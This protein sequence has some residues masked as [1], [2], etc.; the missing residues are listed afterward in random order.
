MCRFFVARFTE[1]TEISSYLHAFSVMAKDS[2]TSNGDRQGDGWGISF[3]TEN[4]EFKTYKSLLPIWEDQEAFTTIP[5]AKIFL[6]H[7]RSASFPNQVGNLNYNQPFIDDDIGFV[8]NGA[9]TGV[10]TP[11]QLNGTIGSQKIFFL[12]R[13]YL[14]DYPEELVLQKVYE[15]I[16]SHSNKIIGMNICMS[17]GNNLHILCSY[18]I[19]SE[20]YTLHYKLIN[21]ATFICSQ[22]LGSVGWYKLKSGETKSF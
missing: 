5:R 9:I 3:R 16:R 19:D 11:L 14:L 1:E 17:I 22:P 12:A 2:R 7:A 6:I 13:Q 4:S 20:Y 21:N 8:F 15:H 10:N 18:T